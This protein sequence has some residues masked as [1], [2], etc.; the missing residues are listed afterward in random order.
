MDTWNYAE[1]LLSRTPV[2]NA[3]AVKWSSY[4]MGITK[5]AVA[6]RDT[7]HTAK[8]ALRKSQDMARTRQ[9]RN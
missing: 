3:H 9:G 7:M 8:I 6:K 4:G 1:I 5:T 2:A